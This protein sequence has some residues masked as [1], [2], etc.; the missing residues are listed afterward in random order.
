M[1]EIFGGILF[2]LVLILLSGIKIVKEHDRLVVFRFGKIIGHKGP[3]LQLIVPLIDRSQYVDTRL[4]ASATAP[5]EVSTLDKIPVR[6]SAL[7]RFQISDPV[8]AVAKVDDPFTHTI[9]SVH[10]VLRSIVSEHYA[11]DLFINERELN[12]SL[13]RTLGRQAKN[14]GVRVK[15]VEIKEL[16]MWLDVPPSDACSIPLAAASPKSNQ[17][18]MLCLES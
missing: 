16:E 7:C 12:S 9:E 2:F 15:S 14:W 5:M 1:N 3:G 17:I 8:K 11:K 4:A 10:T 18:D 13:T 6:L